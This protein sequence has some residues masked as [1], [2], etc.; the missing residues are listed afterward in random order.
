MRET[1]KMT[2]SDF[3]YFFFFIIRKQISRSTI[4]HHLLKSASTYTQ[5]EIRDSIIFEAIYSK[6]EQSQN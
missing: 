5:H 3:G 6:S 1:W 2:N 4:Y